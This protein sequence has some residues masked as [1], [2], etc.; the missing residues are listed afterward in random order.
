MEPI[1]QALIDRTV[2]KVE[3]GVKG[4]TSALSYRVDSTIERTGDAVATLQGVTTVSIVRRRI[5]AQNAV[6]QIYW[7]GTVKL[8][9]TYYHRSPQIFAILLGIYHFVNFISTVI[10][11]VRTVASVVRIFSTISEIL[12]AVFPQ[13]REFINRIYNKVSEFSQ[14][15]GW[16]V[17]GFLHILNAVNGGIGVAG[18]LMGKD[19][20]VMQVEWGQRVVDTTTS[21]SRALSA[22]ADNPGEYIKNLVQ[23]QVFTTSTDINNWWTPVFETINVGFSRATQALSSASSVFQ[24]MIALQTNMPSIVAQYIPQ[25]L[26]DG[27]DEADNF[28]HDTVMPNLNRVNDL[29]SEFQANIN[30]NNATLSKLAQKIAFPGQLLQDVDDLPGFLK[31]DQ[32]M[33][34]D[35]VTSREFEYW[36][37]QERSEILSDLNAFDRIDSALQAPTPEPEF[38]SLEA[39]EGKTI[40]GI[41]VEPQETWMIGGYNSPY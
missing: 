20:N 38:L 13:Y 32:E 12:S 4:Y 34:I 37:N 36:T 8:L 11:V 1:D 25:G 26:W 40:R 24:N 30:A 19:W 6:W 18:A 22:I 39:T 27:L 7:A 28:I 5:E 2:R 17:D 3:A 14:A 33:R 21:I 29:I 9:R 10:S 23:N 41:T 16:G 31:K 35:D 15:V